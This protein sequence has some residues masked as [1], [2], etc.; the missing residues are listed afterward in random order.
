MSTKRK[1]R[2][3]KKQNLENKQTYEDICNERPAWANDEKQEIEDLNWLA[4]F[5]SE[6]KEAIRNRDNNI[7]VGMAFA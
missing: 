4:N 2:L 3:Q 7:T 1:H 6:V 5:K